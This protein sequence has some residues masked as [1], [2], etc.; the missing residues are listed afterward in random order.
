MDNVLLLSILLI[1]MTALLSNVMKQRRRDRVLKEM[2]DFHITMQVDGNKQVWGKMQV[3]SNGLELRYSNMHR[4]RAGLL[5]SSYIMHQEDLD[6]IGLFYRFHNELSPEN[7]QRREDEVQ[8][9]INPSIVSRGKRSLKNLIN[10]F[11]DAIN[12]AFGVFISR[13]KGQSTAIAQQDLYLKKVGTS[14]LGLVG[15][16]YDPILERFIN[17]RVVVVVRGTDETHNFAGFL[18]EYSPSWLSLLDCRVK[19]KDTL[20]ITDITRVRMQ[21]N[22]DIEITLQEEAGKIVLDVSIQN[23]GIHALKIIAIQDA[24]KKVNYYQAINKTLNREDSLS[25]R[26]DDLPEDKSRPIILDK[27]PMTFSMIAPE[28]QSELP[29][30]DTEIYREFLPH[31]DLVFYTERVADIYIP[32]SL[33][34]LRNSA[35]IE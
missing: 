16:V 17:K 6:R 23:F 18:K 1:F 8:G 14:A 21:R 15:N 7:Q 5:T 11:N 34:V 30:M 24:S 27:L 10:A 9:T 13:L 19:Q 3:Y 4:N 31:L 20:N 25:L 12:E 35:D 29:K 33:G 32:R 22:I 26:I 28:R 2:Q